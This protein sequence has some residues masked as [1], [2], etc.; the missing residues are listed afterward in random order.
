MNIEFRYMYRD[1]GNFK[2]FGEIVFG[3]RLNSDSE[4]IHNCITDILGPDLIIKASDLRI[5]DI[6]FQNFP[7]NPELDHEMHEYF[8]VS[9]TD[10]PTS[11]TEQ[12]DI[13]DMLTELKNKSILW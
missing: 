9:E 2:N 8:G 7:Y 12:R 5:P 11:D 10:K 1:M 6:F 13:V 4:D 3:N